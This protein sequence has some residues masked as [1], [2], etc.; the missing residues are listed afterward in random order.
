M[1]QKVDLLTMLALKPDKESKENVER[2]KTN[3]RILEGY[4]NEIRS[5]LKK[6]P[7]VVIVGGG[8][9][10]LMTAFYLEKFDFQISIVEKE[11]FGAAASGRNGG[12]VMMMGRELIELPFARHSIKLW[13]QLS[14][15][16]V[17]T[18]FEQSGHL[19]VARNDV[20]EE[21]LIKAYELYKASG[22]PVEL[23]NN[24]QMKKYTPHLGK[25]NRIGLFSLEDAQSYPF[26]TIQS[27]IKSLKK[28]DV[29]FYPYTKVTDFQ[30][31]GTEITGVVIQNE[32]IKGDYY[33]LCTGPW[34]TEIGKQLNEIIRVRPRRSQLMVTEVSK[35]G[36][37]IPFFTG[38]GFYSRQTHI[39][40]ILFG[41]GGPWEIDGFE[42]KN[43]SYA[44]QLLSKRF[45]EV[46][47]AYKTKQLI[48]GFAGTVEI[49]PDLVPAFG[50]ML[51]WDNGFVS[52]GYHG[53]GYGLSAV[54]GKLMSCVLYDYT[55]NQTLSKDM[56][57]VLS[58]FG[59]QRFKEL[60]KVQG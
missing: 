55:I 30:T 3:D 32:V 16:G 22:I 9:I 2:V 33:L 36:S 31:N 29:K 60:A 52:A 57:S 44:I 51:N 17:D 8:I 59:I 40:N 35:K 15:Y 19:M 12:A 54:M 42:V 50:K 56:E 18:H 48:R 21:R 10:S 27:I 49:T 38:N 53:H 20:E 26:T 46:F 34:T 11:S 43:T 39:G 14:K 7:H 4:F 24:D 6:R 1:S 23:L 45:T 47:P 37:V 28:K 25:E 5:P 13:E 41:G 58:P